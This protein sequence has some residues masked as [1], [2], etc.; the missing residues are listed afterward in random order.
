MP[1]KHFFHECSCMQMAQ[2]PI[3]GVKDGKAKSWNNYNT[4]SE[5]SCFSHFLKDFYPKSHSSNQ[6]PNFSNPS[7]ASK[8]ALPSLVVGLC[9][10]GSETPSYIPCWSRFPACHMDDQSLQ[11]CHPSKS[12]GGAKSVRNSFGKRLP[13][14]MIES[15]NMIDAVLPHFVANDH[16][17][18]QQHIQR[19]A[20]AGALYVAASATAHCTRLPSLVA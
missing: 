3:D 13:D 19:W 7:R 4:F 14:Q 15:V 8:D 6:V 5:T 1:L 9:L 2:V 18:A 17:H 10:P 11:E 20:T 16:F 12:Q